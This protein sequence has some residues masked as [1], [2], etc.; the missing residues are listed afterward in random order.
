MIAFVSQPT[1][2]DNLVTNDQFTAAMAEIKG[3]A[4]IQAE[5]LLN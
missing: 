1:N 2:H 4:E 5:C 3:M